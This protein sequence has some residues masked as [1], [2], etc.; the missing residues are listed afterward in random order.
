MLITGSQALIVGAICSAAAAIAHLICIVWGAPAYRLMGAGEKMARAVEAGK[1][2]PT[3]ITFAIS[4]VLLLWTAYALGGAG[5]IGHLPLSRLALP[6]ICAVY[7]GRAV[8]FPLLRPAFPENSLTFWLV[9]SSICLF[10]GLV[11]L[12]GILYL[13]HAL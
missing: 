6:A 3:L 12:Y 2:Q 5:V 8:A 13:W 11:H 9:S 7:L 10:I 4:G 1:I